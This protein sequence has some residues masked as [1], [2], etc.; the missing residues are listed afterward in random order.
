[1]EEISKKD[2][3]Q[4]I[5]ESQEMDEMGYTPRW[6]S[7]SSKSGRKEKGQGEP[8]YNKETGE[9][10]YPEPSRVKPL[11]PQKP[12][13][14]K[15]KR[16]V[17]KKDGRVEELPIG[18]V[19]NPLKNIGK[20]VVF[21]SLDE[22]ETEELLKENKVW[23]EWFEDVVTPL[24]GDDPMSH[25][26]DPE[27][28]I[29]F[30]DW[31][32][33]VGYSQ[34]KRYPEYLQKIT[35]SSNEKLMAKTGVDLIAGKGSKD[36][37]AREKFLRDLYPTIRE[38]LSGLND[39]M[40][41]M[42]FPS[43]EFNTQEPGKQKRHTDTYSKKENEDVSLESHNVFTYNNYREFAEEAADILDIHDDPDSKDTGFKIDRVGENQARQKN[44]GIRWNFE[45]KQVK[46]S[47]AYKRDPLTRVYKLDREG[48]KAEEKDYLT[49]TFFNLDGKYDEGAK[50]YDW[51]VAVRVE[52]SE[53]LREESKH[54]GGL[55]E[56]VTFRKAASVPVPHGLNYSTTSSILKNHPQIRKALELVLDELRDELISYDPVPQL[57][58]RIFKK[59]SETTKKYDLS[60]NEIVGLIKQ[61]IHSTKK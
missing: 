19:V 22:N 49:V 8:K 16:Y 32:K 39:T 3:L 51:E 10:E 23:A 5:L 41:M 35:P 15:L 47:D 44:P 17:T 29:H 18:Y 61:T 54:Y 37:T 24:I 40:L 60:E 12:E 11:F 58:M 21:V 56:L 53:K 48:K 42:G 34:D 13:H 9:W 14:E 25:S 46:T 38:K 6:Q 45:R 20:G 59:R 52:I 31:I 36:V 26:V 33:D 50:K 1:M 27:A 43:I 7:T 28:T 57:E 2:L 30:V 4:N 55:K